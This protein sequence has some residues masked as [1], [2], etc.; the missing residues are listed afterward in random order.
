MGGGNLFQVLFGTIK[1]KFASLVSKI[2]LWTSWSYLRTRITNLIKD[3]FYKLLDVR[4]KNKNDYYTMFG[5]MVSK[6]LAY[7]IIVMIGVLS[8]WYITATTNIFSSIGTTGGLRTY[9]YNSVLLRLANNKVRIKGRSD[10]IAYVGDV[11]K[12][13]V[14]G[15]G[16]LYSPNNV[17]LY[18]GAFLKNKYEGMGSQYYDSGSIHYIG[19]FHDNLYEGTGTLYRED[20]SVEYVGNFFQGMKEGQGKLQDGGNNAIYEGNFSSDEIVYSELLG[21]DASEIR[22]MYFGG[23][24]L[25]E[26]VDD[27]GGGDAVYLKDINA[28]CYEVSDGSAADDAPKTQAVYVLSDKFKIGSLAADSVQELNAIFGAPT[29]EGNSAAIFPEAVAI[30]AVNVGEYA[31]NGKI[32]MDTTENFSDDIVVNN[33]DRDYTVYVYTYERGDLIYSFVSNQAGSGF[34]FYSIMKASGEA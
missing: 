24:V 16:E 2:K 6:R 17:L 7:F 32:S 25:Y 1:S 18:S 4:P 3:F 9:K 8:L 26:A 14:T 13:Y 34:Y 12:G 22:Q 23:Q 33:F 27:L 28:I 29:Y 31:M 10:Y 21:K 30:N 15:Q 11:S 5:W 20:G 19:N